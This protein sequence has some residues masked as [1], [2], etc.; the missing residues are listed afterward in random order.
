M[1]CFGDFPRCVLVT[2]AN[3]F[4]GAALAA[5]LTQDGYAV[6]GSVRR[7]AATLPGGVTP[8]PVADLGADADWSAALDG[9]DAIVHC[10]ARVHVMRDQAPDPLAAFRQVNVQGTLRLARQA[11]AAGVRR[12]VYLSSVKVLGEFTPPGQPFQAHAVPA[13]QDAYGQSKLETELALQAL[14]QSVAME[15]VIVRPPLVYGPGVGANFAALMRWVQRGWPLPLGALENRRSLVARDN[16]VD[17]LCLCLHHPAAAGQVFLVSDGEDVSSP[18]LVRRLA[19]AMRRPARL[20][21]VPQRWLECAAAVLGKRAAV[22]RL[23]SSL[24]VDMEK[25]H[26]QLGWQPPL[27][28][29]QGLQLAVQA[30]QVE[31]GANL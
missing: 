25:T 30:V 3:G 21:P 24:Q 1:P 31:P 8:V 11:A 5:R 27:G 18:D 29:D 28:L 16:L 7:S 23:C 14:A 13:P 2:G 20:W 6:R 15:L 26:A 19:L 9:V 4:V 12:F 17:L 22:Q 10:A